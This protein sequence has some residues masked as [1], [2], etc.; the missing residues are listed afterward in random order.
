MEKLRH[1]IVRYVSGYHPAFAAALGT[2]VS[3]LLD[4]LHLPLTESIFGYGA[5]FSLRK[6][7]NVAQASGLLSLN[8]HLE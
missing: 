1:G 5:A 3:Y 4:R 6:P 2:T 8:T 7:G